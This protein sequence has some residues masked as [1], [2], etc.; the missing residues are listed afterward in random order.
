MCN[1]EHMKMS[2]LYRSDLIEARVHKHTH[3]HT[4]ILSPVVL[5]I[6]RVGGLTV[7]TSN[8][9]SGSGNNCCISD[10]QA[11]FAPASSALSFLI[12]EV[13]TFFPS[14]PLPARQ[15]WKLVGRELSS[16]ASMSRQFV[17][18]SLYILHVVCV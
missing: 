18:S 16:V 1:L 9:L 11:D 7:I 6:F 14:S 15:M 3:T 10:R 8:G 13:Y 2:C 17:K 5:G 12:H 4:T